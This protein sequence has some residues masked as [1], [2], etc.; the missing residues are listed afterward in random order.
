MVTT[1]AEAAA[2][3][4]M[5]PKR[6][7]SIGSPTEPL[8]RLHWRT[9]SLPSF[10]RGDHEAATNSTPSVRAT[11]GRHLSIGPFSV[12]RFASK[13]CHSNRDR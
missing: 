8:T 11:T 3:A 9:A 5:V 12:K 6:S 7:R 13:I 2:L 4:T 1:I 10:R